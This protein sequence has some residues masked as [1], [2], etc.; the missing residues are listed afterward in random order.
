MCT[1][2]RH[3]KIWS[4]SYYYLLC[5]I[6]IKPISSAGTVSAEIE[7]H[8]DPASG[9]DKTWRRNA[10]LAKLK[11]YFNHASAFHTSRTTLITTYLKEYGHSTTAYNDIKPYIEILDVEERTVLLSTLIESRKAVQERKHEDS[12][13]TSVSYLL[14]NLKVSQTSLTDRTNQILIRSTLMNLIIHNAVLLLMTKLA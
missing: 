1:L 9:I 3:L 5:G 10:S 8:L 7:A 2:L 4:K 13:S 6:N 12:A 11:W 14:S